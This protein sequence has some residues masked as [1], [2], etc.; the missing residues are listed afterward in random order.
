MQPTSSSS[1]LLLSPESWKNLA[2]RQAYF[3]SS[4]RLVVINPELALSRLSQPA[5]TERGSPP[6]SLQ[7]K[8]GVR[9]FG[10]ASLRSRSLYP[11]STVLRLSRSTPLWRCLSQG[12]FPSVEKSLL[13]TGLLSR[14]EPTRSTSRQRP[15][16][17]RSRWM[18][19]FRANSRSTPFR[20][21]PPSLS[22]CRS[23]GT[24]ES[25]KLSLSKRC[26]S[27]L[28]MTSCSRK[29]LHLVSRD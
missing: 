26:L 28:Q 16:R 21:F 22:R 25:L 5:L 4:A 2:G 24:G 29:L 6:P 1:T 12:K 17:R 20:V 23:S 15:G 13:T 19:R 9:T 27:V 14:P 8:S 7:V 18:G 10:P 3:P 11:L